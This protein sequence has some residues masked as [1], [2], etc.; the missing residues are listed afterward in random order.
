MPLPE[1]FGSVMILSF[2]NQKGGVGKSTLSV[3]VAA[4][5]AKKPRKVLLIDADTQG[6]VA[7]WAALRED[8][9]FRVVSMARDNM[10]RDAM[11]MAVDYQ[12]VIID[13][14]PG[15]G[16]ITRAAII[17]SDVVLVP[18]EPSGASIWA[19]RDT[20]AQIQEAQSYKPSLKGAFVVSRK[21]ANTVLGRDVRE[22]AAT[23]GFPILK[24]E[25]VNRVGFAEALTMGTSVFEWAGGREA[26]Q[27]I[28][29]LCLELERIN[30]GEEMIHTGPTAESA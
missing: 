23:N 22:M 1:Q 13:G 29:K 16:K 11:A 20:I 27:D 9:K 3:N 28:Q 6:T 25:I 19:S 10:A 14:P 7:A 15:A 17:A 8:S 2:L 26:A 21:L 12:D 5:L 4:Y 18:I 30:D 24:S